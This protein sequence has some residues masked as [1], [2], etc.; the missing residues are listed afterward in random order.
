MTP[1]L[2]SNPRSDRVKAVRALSRR[3]VRTQPGLFVADGPQSVREAVTH[4]PDV[5]R[6]V[7]V[8]PDA[9]RRHAALVEVALHAGVPVHQ[10]TDEVLEAM[11]DTRLAV[12]PQGLLAVCRVPSPSLDEVLA[13]APRLIC[14]LTHVRDPGNAG[15]VIRAADAAGADA[16]IVSVGSVDAFSPKVVRSTAGSVFHLP[17]VTGLEVEDILARLR[18]AG[19]RLLAADGSGQTM[20]DDVDLV[21]PHA[22]VMG[23]EAWGL[24]QQVL[25]RC[26]DVVRVPIHGLAESLNLAMAATL[27]LYASARSQ[28]RRP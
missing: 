22:W 10:V 11:G 2:L 27:C 12:S 3:A 18:A 19:L 13:A 1:G 21:P 5:V 6:D 8:T 4:R 7:Y 25:D 16:V 28:T 23:N 24:E 26:D 15:T 9:T 20:L 14:V 17:V